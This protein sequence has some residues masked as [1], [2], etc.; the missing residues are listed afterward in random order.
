MSYASAATTGEGQF[1]VFV[2]TGSHHFLMDEPAA[3]GGLDSGPNP[4]DLL[5]SALAGC[6]LMT[7]KLYADRKGWTLD[8]LK[9]S[10][11]HRKDAA[12]PKDRFECIVELGDVTS[13]QRERLLYI[14]GRCP[15]H[16]VLE[17]GAEVPTIVDPDEP[18]RE[19]A[20]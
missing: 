1:Q 8:Q 14:A 9:V 10:V 16:L 3:A 15:V 20:A 5:C 11:T 7:L 18:F 4:F 2:Q 6:T 19:L 13:E 12:E 17:R